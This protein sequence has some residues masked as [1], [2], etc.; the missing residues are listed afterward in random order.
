MREEVLEQAINISKELEDGIDQ[1]DDRFAFL[2]EVLAVAHK[3]LHP[4]SA[5]GE[6]WV[7]LGCLSQVSTLLP[8]I[9]L[10]K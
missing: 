1:L 10:Q 4:D 2:R 6:N 5:R 9:F 7:K 3:N 8:L